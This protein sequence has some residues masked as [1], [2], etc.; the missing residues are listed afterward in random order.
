MMV[1]LF[2]SVSALAMRAGVVHSGITVSIVDRENNL[3][4][5][6]TCI[7]HCTLAE[8]RILMN[9]AMAFCLDALVEWTVSYINKCNKYNI[10]E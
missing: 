8:V 6:I 7:F 1:V 2:N 4:T 10:Q 5:R 3:S 9:N